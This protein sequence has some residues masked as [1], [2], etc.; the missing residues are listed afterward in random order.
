[1]FRCFMVLVTLLAVGLTLPRRAE[2]CTAALLEGPAQRLVI[3]SYDWHDGSGWL[4]LNPA[5]Q[6]KKALRLRTGAASLRWT[7][8]HASITFNQY[9]LHLPNSGMNQAGL[10]VETLWLKDSRYPKADQRPALNELQLVQ[11]LLDRFDS[12]SEAVT[13]LPTVRVAPVHGRVHWMVCDKSGACASIEYLKGRLTV[14][15]G[16]SL[17]HRALANHTYAQSQ[18]SYQSRGDRGTRGSLDRFARAT[19]GHALPKGRQAG[20]HHAQRLLERVQ[21]GSY[22]KWQLIWQPAKGRVTFRTRSKGRAWP[23][24]WRNFSFTDTKATCATGS[25]A[26]TLGDASKSPIAALLRPLSQA[27]LRASVRRRLRRLGMPR[28]GA[29]ATRIAGYAAS[30][31]CARAATTQ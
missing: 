22:T 14:H 16:A 13:A 3:K 28:A 23:M 11:W 2:A 4:V 31:G 20:L 8:R 6:A 17:P 12:V 30:I 15:H 26:M 7:S 24:G 29:V 5:G 9:G 21:A 25:V 18:R 19:K 10:V 27:K 1:M